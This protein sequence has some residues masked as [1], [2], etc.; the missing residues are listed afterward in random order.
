MSC[1]LGMLSV[2]FATFRYSPLQWI[3][4]DGKAQT[5]AVMTH[6][7]RSGGAPRAHSIPQQ[8]GG[9]K[10]LLD[11]R[12]LFSGGIFS[13]AVL[14]GGWGSMFRPGRHGRPWPSG[15]R[16]G[17]MPVPV[18][19]VAISPTDNKAAG[20]DRRGTHR[21]AGRCDRSTERNRRG[22]EVATNWLGTPAGGPPCLP[23]PAPA[24]R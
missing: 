12:R 7:P 13:H 24:R 19:Q 15:K 3:R 18:P 10:G 17:R 11:K 2:V 4:P 20:L 23:S 1:M 5:E 16:G 9:R 14:Q 8:R 6:S 22:I 21:Q